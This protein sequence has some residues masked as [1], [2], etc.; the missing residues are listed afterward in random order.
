MNI[1]TCI[2]NKNAMAFNQRRQSQDR[3]LLADLLTLTET[4]AL[5]M[6]PY[7]SKLFTFGKEGNIK[8][9]DMPHLDCGKGEC[10]F[11]EEVDPAAFEEEIETLIIYRWNKVYPGD[12]FFTIDIGEDS[13]WKRIESKDFV[14]SSHEKITR[15]IY[16]RGLI[17][18]E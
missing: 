6:S 14:G 10:C 4:K 13:P 15:E 7:T 16:A 2:D 1:I 8:I 3:L 11:I 18:E 5:Y 9:S 12:L 17:N